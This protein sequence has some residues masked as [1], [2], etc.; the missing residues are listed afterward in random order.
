MGREK[1]EN[2]KG[3]GGSWRD[4]GTKFRCGGMKLKDGVSKGCLPE[5]K[6]GWVSFALPGDIRRGTMHSFKNGCVVTDVA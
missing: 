6:S 4:C 2:E 1:D 5:K 3:E